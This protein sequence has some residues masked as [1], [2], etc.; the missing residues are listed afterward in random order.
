MNA[1][2]FRQLL[3][4]RQRDLAENELDQRKK[5]TELNML[6]RERIEIMDDIITLEERLHDENNDSNY[7]E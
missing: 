3:T 4:A 1:H 6:M 2:T 7:E 5:T